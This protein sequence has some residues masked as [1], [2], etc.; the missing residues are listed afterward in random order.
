MPRDVRDAYLAPYDSWANR[1]ADPSGSSRTSRCGR[2]IAL[3]TSS[4]GSRTGSTPLAAV[5]MLIAWGMKDF[6]FDQPLPRRMGPPLPRGRGPSLR[7]GRALRARRRAGR[8]SRSGAPRCA[9]VPGGP[10]RL[11]A[12][13]TSVESRPS[14]PWPDCRR[15]SPRTC[16]RWPGAG[17]TRLA[18]RRARAGRDRAGRVRYTHLTFRQ[19]D[20]DSD[21][22]AARPERDRDRPRGPGRADGQAGPRFLRAD[23]RA[24]QGGRRAGPDRSRDGAQEP[25]PVPGARPSPRSFIGIPKAVWRAAV[26]GWGTEIGAARDPGRTATAVDRP[27]DARR[28]P[29]RW[30]ASRRRRTRGRRSSDPVRP[31]ETAA[32]LFTSGSTGPPKG[33]VYTH[34]IFEAQVERFRDLYGIEP[35]EID[36]CT[37]PLFALFAPALGMTAIVPDMDPTRPARVDPDE[38]LRGD[39]GLRRDEPVRLAGLA[40]PGRPGAAPPGA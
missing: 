35:G 32:I 26:L 16:P 37:F 33:A 25:G 2:A 7:R 4:R 38:D 21:R 5:P 20:Q 1:I 14:G 15:T 24:V 40:P 31:D 6:V 36:L 29:P 13:S 17:R 9:A 11:I 3:T 10:S 18:R 8:R 23:L 39:R 30:A 28:H 19:L 27:D 12:R 34:G 22:I